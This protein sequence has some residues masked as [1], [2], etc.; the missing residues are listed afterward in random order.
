MYPI[1]VVINPITLPQHEYASGRS[2]SPCTAY[3]WDEDTSPWRVPGVHVITGGSARRTSNECQHSTRHHAVNRAWHAALSAV[4]APYYVIVGWER[5]KPSNVERLAQRA[6]SVVTSSDGHR[7]AAAACEGACLVQDVL[8]GGGL[9][10]R[11]AE[12]ED[13]RLAHHAQDRMLGRGLL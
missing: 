4:E 2:Q 10:G 1:L 3:P 7:V 11:A 8:G 12:A 5:L 13:K 6:P 9:L